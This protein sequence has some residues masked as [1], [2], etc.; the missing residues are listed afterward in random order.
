MFSCPLVGGADEKHEMLEQKSVGPQQTPFNS[1]V[2]AD[3]SEEKE[4]RVY[5][6]ESL[7][8]DFFEL[9]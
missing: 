7:D 8:D 3:L 2:M 6:Q 9:V 4:E 1:P 5:E